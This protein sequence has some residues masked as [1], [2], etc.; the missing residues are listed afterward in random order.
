MKKP[1]HPARGFLPAIGIASVLDACD[2]QLSFCG[3]VKVAVIS[4]L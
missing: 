3:K 2:P 4:V 1:K